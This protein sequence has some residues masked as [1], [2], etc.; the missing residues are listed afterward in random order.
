MLTFDERI[1]A[2]EASLVKISNTINT[3]FNDGTIDT[4]NDELGAVLDQIFDNLR[5]IRERYRIIRD[6][7]TMADQLI[8]PA[9]RK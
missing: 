7:L 9:T 2:I 3:S 1:T 4:T 8:R 5:D 6:H